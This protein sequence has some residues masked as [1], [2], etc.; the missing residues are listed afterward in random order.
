MVAD[1]FNGK[2]F[3][4]D[5]LGRNVGEIKKSFK[6][7]S[8]NEGSLVSRIFS[9]ISKKRTFDMLTQLD[10]VGLVVP[11]LEHYVRY[12]DF[13]VEQLSDMLK[14]GE[15]KFVLFELLVITHLIF[16]T[17]GER[18]FDFDRYFRTGRNDVISIPEPVVSDSDF[19]YSILDSINTHGRT[20]PLEDYVETLLI[21]SGPYRGS[22]YKHYRFPPGR[23]LYRWASPENDVQIMSHMWS[24]QLGKSTFLENSCV[25]YMKV[26]PS[27]I[28]YAFSTANLAEK[29]VKKRLEPRALKAGVKFITNNWG[30]KDP[31]S[32]DSGNKLLSKE[33]FGGN[34]DAVTVGSA[35]Q[36]AAESKRVLFKEEIGKWPKEVGDEGGTDGVVDA[37]TTS[38]GK[39]KKIFN[40]SSPNLAQSCLM[41]QKFLEGTQHHYHCSC[42]ICGELY[43]L[44]F[45]FTESHGLQ[46][47][48]KDGMVDRESIHYKCPS[49]GGKWHEHQK[50]YAM[51]ENRGATWVAHAV[52]MSEHVISTNMNQLYSVTASWYDI[53]IEHY[54]TVLN[55]SLEQVFWNTVL[56]LPY[57]PRGTRPDAEKLIS[58]RDM[59]YRS[60]ELPDDV[61]YLVASV[62]VQRGSSD[63]SKKNPSRLEVEILGI[64]DNFITKSIEYLKI[65]GDTSTVGQGAWAEL[66]ILFDS[67]AFRYESKD[68]LLTLAP[69]VWFIDS[70]DGERMD[71]VYHYCRTR[72]QGVYPSKGLSKITD[73]EKSSVDKTGSSDF[74]RY[75]KVAVA[76][77]LWVYQISTNYYK[78]RVYRDINTTIHRASDT[79]EFAGKCYFPRDYSDEYFSMLTAE[80]QRKDGSFHCPK[81][82]RNEALD[83]RVYALAAA[84][85]WIQELISNL[86]K[87]AQKSGA[88]A[89]DVKKIDFRT[90]VQAIRKFNSDMRQKA[91]SHKPQG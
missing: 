51:D 3:V 47:T 54:K 83:C 13:T 91:T 71:T 21:P 39:R 69:V 14:S 25:Y 46:Y 23:Q 45:G 26:C 4:T 42:P 38:W 11:H 65:L 61:L 10:K 53:C 70:G 88:S 89:D 76:D 79:E 48:I 80:D 78:T 20:M 12:Q 73:T 60:G 50:L 30:D 27:E 74:R 87:R 34:F 33:F 7:L 32:R 86:R 9:A 59:T 90:A 31:K 37:R 72:G 58:L 77:D 5:V 84:D 44:E 62:D 55:P 56:G 28:M 8:Q 67:Y 52:P 85:A 81:G 24:V 6:K 64:C 35:S 1:I 2:R 63:P 82:R 49:C 40:V 22:I 66:D 75:R 57:E 18:S 43:H 15:S 68:G 29:T 41:Y 36:T 16:S 19:Y 17:T